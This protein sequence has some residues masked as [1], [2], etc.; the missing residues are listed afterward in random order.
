MLGDNSPQVLLDTMF[1]Y[2]GLYFALRGGEE[3]RRLRHKPCQ[4]VLYEPPAGPHYLVYTEDKSKTNQGGLLHRNRAPKS[5]TH[6]ENKSNPKRCLVQLFKNYT[7]RCLIDR[8]DGALY[9][10]PLKRP[11]GNTWFQRSPVGHNTLSKMISRMMSS[12]KIPGNYSNHSLRSTATT[13]LFNAHIDEQ[14]IMATAAQ[15]VSGATNE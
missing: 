13:R 4:I 15:P 10:K 11:K 6:Y 12:A 1:Y 3:H 14:L 9:L 8:P 2:I 5:V 7:S